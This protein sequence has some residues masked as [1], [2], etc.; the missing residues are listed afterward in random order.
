MRKAAAA[1]VA[2]A[3]LGASA[4]DSPSASFSRSAGGACSASAGGSFVA[5]EARSDGRGSSVGSTGS[6]IASKGHLA[7]QEYNDAAA[8]VAKLLSARH[9]T[10]F[11]REA[12]ANRRMDELVVIAAGGVP[13]PNSS[14]VAPA[15][16]ATTTKVAARTGPRAK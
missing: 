9:Y 16:A 2:V 5:Q 7:E 12:R 13:T 1:A 11:A 14:S 15:R 4:S 6:G 3:K 10:R 8:R